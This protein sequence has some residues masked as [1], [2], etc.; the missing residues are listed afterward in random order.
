MATRTPLAD[1]NN[2]HIVTD[3][4]LN[5]LPRGQIGYVLR[6]SNQT[7]ITTTVDLTGLTLTVTLAVGRRYRW[8]YHGE[9]FSTVTD[10]A[11]VASITDAAGTQLARDTG[12]AATSGQRV[13]CE[14]E[15]N[16]GGIS[17]TRKARLG[18][19]SG[20]GTYTH[21]ADATNPAKLTLEDIGPAFT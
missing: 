14:Y 7:T 5:S 18:R 2:G 12:L 1:L 10:G 19:A 17:V 9:F 11:Y 21:A 15:E 4:E 13:G 20:T 6:T 8:V 16:G 3:D